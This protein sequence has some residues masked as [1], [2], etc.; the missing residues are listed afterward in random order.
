[1]VS[2]RNG[3]RT[4]VDTWHDVNHTSNLSLSWDKRG[5]R[6]KRAHFL[7]FTR[8]REEK[9]ERGESSFIPQSM[10]FRGSIFVGPRAKVHLIDKRYAW[11]PE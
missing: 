5:I 1:M 10:K 7:L 9:R 8:E 11:V 6:A 2:G 3:T 4:R